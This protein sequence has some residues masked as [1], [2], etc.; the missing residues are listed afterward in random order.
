M[1]SCVGVTAEAVKLV[2]VGLG[3][4]V[5][6]AILLLELDPELEFGV[7]A[8][9]TSVDDVVVCARLEGEEVTGGKVPIAGGGGGGATGVDDDKVTAAVVDVSKSE[10]LVRPRLG[11]V[12][13]EVVET[14]VVVSSSDSSPSLTPSTSE[15]RSSSSA[16]SRLDSRLV[17]W[18]AVVMVA[19]ANA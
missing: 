2:S 3:A 6:F 14:N 12:V 9:T 15:S 18:G 19:E 16:A 5:C 7:G 17:G 4:A 13:A 8:A 11:A 10:L 1:E